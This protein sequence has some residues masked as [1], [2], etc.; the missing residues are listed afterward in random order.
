MIA[1]TILEIQRL[2][3]E[4]PPIEQAQARAFVDARYPPPGAGA[5]RGS[6]VGSLT[7]SSEPLF[8]PPDEPTNEPVQNG[9][10]EPVRTGAMNKYWSSSFLK[11][12]S[13]YPKKT[14]KKE[15]LRIWKRL[16]PD[17]ALTD[18][19]LNSVREQK[20]SENWL[21]ENGQFIP[22]PKTW[23]NQGRWDDEPV[24]IG[25]RSGSSLSEKTRCNAD[26]ARA[27]VQHTEKP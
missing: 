20:T 10:N 25:S 18:K 21:K 7:G 11:F 17:R 14:G 13:E 6:N 8:E 12:W 2:L 4:H 23:L 5:K 22:H 16:Q 3:D 15:A 24:Q 1:E 27:F 26:V 19:I 9:A